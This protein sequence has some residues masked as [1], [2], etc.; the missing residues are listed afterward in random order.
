MRRQLVALVNQETGVDLSQIL[1]LRNANWRADGVRA[2]G[3]SID[4]WVSIRTT[5]TKYDYF[6]HRRPQTEL[7]VVIV[8]EDGRDRVYGV[9]RVLGV[10]STGTLG[11]LATEPLRQ[12]Y[13]DCGVEN[14]P[15]RKF[16]IEQI[17]FSATGLPVAGWEGKEICSVARSDGTLFWAIEVELPNCPQT[18]PVDR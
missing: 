4:Q 9:Y 5:D 6:W 2:R 3:A 13:I 12:S 17:P 11:S 8:R 10:E 1:L 7:V 18:G 15:A 16:K 14:K